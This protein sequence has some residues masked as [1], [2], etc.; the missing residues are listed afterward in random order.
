MPDPVQ[1]RSEAAR[2]EEWSADCLKWRGRI[3]SGAFSHWCHEWDGL[4]VDD[5]TPEFES[6]TCFPETAKAAVRRATHGEC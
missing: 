2:L 3:L 5:T 6:C 1:Q 4:P